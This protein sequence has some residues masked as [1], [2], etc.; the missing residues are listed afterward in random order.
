MGENAPDFPIVHFP[1]PTFPASF[2]LVP[3][4]DDFFKIEQWG[5]LVMDEGNGQLLAGPSS[6][7]G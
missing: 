5:R 6:L 2:L 3:D 1:L 7:G 4:V